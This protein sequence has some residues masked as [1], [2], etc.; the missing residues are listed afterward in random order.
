MRPVVDRLQTL[1]AGQMVFR[2][3]NALD[4]GDGETAFRR[5]ALPGHPSYV[6]FTPGGVETYRTFGVV[7]ESVL[8]EAI[9][10]ALDSG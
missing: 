2:Y 10:A 4:G 7:E 1:F 5:L 9:R 8:Q 6:I 3:V